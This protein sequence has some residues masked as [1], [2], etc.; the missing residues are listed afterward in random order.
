VEGV[1]HGGSRTSQ[2][3][4]A[5]RQSSYHDAHT[6]AE[7]E[8]GPVADI[9]SV[10]PLSV[11]VTGAIVVGPRG[12]RYTDPA[13]GADVSG[14]AGWRVDVHPPSGP[15]YRDVT[16]LLQDED[17]GIGTHRMPYTEHVEGTV[18]ITSRC[19]A[20]TSMAITAVPTR[21]RDCGVCSGC[22][23]RVRA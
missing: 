22:A 14:R 2:R 17:A 4:P 8:S 7:I 16:L 20:T 18:G 11:D 15:S 1:G 12:A 13:T 10:E 19:P 5:V 21:R 9:H 23:R 6:G 3:A